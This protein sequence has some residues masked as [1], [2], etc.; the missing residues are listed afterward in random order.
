[1]EWLVGQPLP[2]L[3]RHFEQP[4]GPFLCLFATPSEFGHFGLPA[5]HKNF[6]LHT[7]NYYYKF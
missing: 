2:C 5:V 1:M 7:K 3:S 4:K 6:K